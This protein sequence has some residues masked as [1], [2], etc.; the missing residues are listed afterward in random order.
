MP[1]RE[2]VQI[3]EAIDSEQIEQ[4]RIQFKEYADSLHFDLSFQDFEK[5]LSELPG[6]YAPPTGCALLAFDGKLSA[7]CVAMRRIDPEIC[8]MKRLYVRPEFQGKGIGKLLVTAVIDVA[9]KQKYRRMRLDT[10]PSM[11]SAITLYQSLG[12]V[13]IDSYRENPIEGALFLELDLIPDSSA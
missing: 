4:L 3:V 10:V 9:R 2:Q 6:K 5:E 13:E 7:G 8:E 1:E 12:F 11:K